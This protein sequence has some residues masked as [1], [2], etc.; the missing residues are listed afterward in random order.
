MVQHADIDHTGLPGVGGG[1]GG[2]V[3]YDINR[4]T[5]GDITLNNVDGAVVEGNVLGDVGLLGLSFL[6]RLNMQREGSTMTLT[7]RF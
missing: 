3:G 6:N 4:Y 2:I 1:T 7:R 5:G